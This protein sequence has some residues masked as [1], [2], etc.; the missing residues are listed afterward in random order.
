MWN[1]D[2]WLT[3]DYSGAGNLLFGFGPFGGIMGVL[4]I[5]VLLILLYKLFKALTPGTNA[6]SDKNDSLMILKS[7]FARGE[8]SLDEY[9]RM[10]DTLMHR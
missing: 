5:I 2:G 4:I 10:K 8:I 3:G 9:Q 6:A 1:C 7:R